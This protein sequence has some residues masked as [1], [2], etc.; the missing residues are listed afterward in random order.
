MDNKQGILQCGFSKSLDDPW[1]NAEFF[2]VD[3]HWKLTHSN[4][5][6]E[7]RGENLR[8]STRMDCLLCPLPFN[9]CILL[10]LKCWHSRFFFL[11]GCQL[12]V[13]LNC[14]SAWWCFEVGN[15][16]CPFWFYHIVRDKPAF[17]LNALCLTC[18]LLLSELVSLLAST[19]SM[20]TSWYRLLFCRKW[21]RRRWR[22]FFG[23]CFI[24]HPIKS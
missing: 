18:Y 19:V 3:L 8:I 24:I 14:V 2:H 13:Q 23:R 21:K 15:H 4:S 10:L 7:L 6:S 16:P 17:S 9:F 1:Y 5:L 12:G 22:S 20:V 11:A